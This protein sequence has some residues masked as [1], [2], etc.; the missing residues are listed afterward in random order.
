MLPIY[1]PDARLE[2]LDVLKAPGRAVKQCTGMMIAR[3]HA[4]DLGLE[5][6]APSEYLTSGAGG[7]ATLYGVEYSY[8][9]FGRVECV[10]QVE[11][12]VVTLLAIDAWQATARVGLPK[13][14]PDARA[15]AWGRST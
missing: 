8:N 12:G 4:M 1:H 15:R 14:A 10:Y 9:L 2:L 7:Y 5:P 6:L 11:A 3:H 13:S